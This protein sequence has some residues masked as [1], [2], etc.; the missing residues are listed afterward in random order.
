MSLLLKALKRLETHSTAAPSPPF[1]GESLTADPTLWDAELPPTLVEPLP[2]AFAELSADVNLWPEEIT[3]LSTEEAL[4]RAELNALSIPSN[5]DS[6][7]NSPAT[8]PFAVPVTEATTTIVEPTVISADKMPAAP[9]EVNQR[10]E[11][12][13]P[14]EIIAEAIPTKPIL[15]IFTGDDSDFDPVDEAPESVEAGNASAAI[16]SVAKEPPA[17][18]LPEFAESQSDRAALGARLSELRLQGLCENIASQI[19]ACE[20]PV[21][22]LV[23]VQPLTDMDSL[24][25]KI[26][27]QFAE[28]LGE[29][30]RLIDLGI[31]HEGAKINPILNLEETRQ[32]SSL[33]VVTAD[34]AASLSLAAWL[35]A[36]DAVYLVV[37]LPRTPRRGGYDAIE[38]LLRRK[39]HLAGCILLDAA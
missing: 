20:H 18:I 8:I 34:S 30:P 17:W 22:L 16:L 31:R 19:A 36:C 11:T 24:V 2:A 13:G 28:R 23:P 7:L 32:E 12:I 37:D 14:E 4:F 39:S 38:Q 33:V 25:E 27:L 15:V 35:P 1:H 26:A 10:P 21:V 5:L 29:R 6:E 9:L 3:Q